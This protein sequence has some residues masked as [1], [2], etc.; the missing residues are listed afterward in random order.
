MRLRDA[1]LADEVVV[2]QGDRVMPGQKGEPVGFLGGTLLLPAGP[3]KMAL[4]TGAPIVPIFSVRTGDAKV[5][6]FIE[7]PI[8]VQPDDGD[9][10]GAAHPALIEWAAVL[11][12]Y[13]RSYPDQWLMLR[14]AWCEDAGS[15]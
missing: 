6:L 3:V 2:L 14:P 12:R 4:A 11:E 7:E 5:R 15:A 1:L 10:A 8:D 13:V 9:A